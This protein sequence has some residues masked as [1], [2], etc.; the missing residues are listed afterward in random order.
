MHFK[1]I[2]KALGVEMLE[3]SAQPSPPSAI[4]GIQN[5][6]GACGPRDSHPKGHFPLLLGSYRCS[7][8]DTI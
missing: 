6:T 8:D 5:T 7:K 2:Q 3:H 1:M 4:N